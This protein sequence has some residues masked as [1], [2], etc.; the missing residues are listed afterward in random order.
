MIIK[1]KINDDL[2]IE[3]EADKE[4]DA[5]KAAARL[6]EIFKH[7]R[8]GRCKKKDVK[9]VCRKDKDENDWL[10]IVCQNFNE[11][12][13]KLVFSTVK[14]KGG[15]I[16]PKTRWNHLSETQATQRADEKDYS[17]NHNGWLPNGGWYIFKKNK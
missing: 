6:T 7:D 11:C 3:E 5:F 13:A 1:V 17:D 14:G 12:G 2:W 8:C 10:E 16:Y 9:F 4:V 15:E